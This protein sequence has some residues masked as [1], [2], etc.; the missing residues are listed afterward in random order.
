MKERDMR[1]DLIPTI[2]TKVIHNRA[3]IEDQIGEEEEVDL[4]EEEGEGEEEEEAEEE[5]VALADSDKFVDKEMP[6]NQLP[7]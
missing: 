1:K 4:E 5:A 3:Q 7:M 6:V 2:L